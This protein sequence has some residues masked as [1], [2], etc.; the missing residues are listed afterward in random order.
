MLQLN[1]EAFG[2]YCGGCY[3]GIPTWRPNT[4]TRIG[5]I[6]PTK[7]R[8]SSSGLLVA[9]DYRKLPD[10]LHHG[11]TSLQRTAKGYYTRASHTPPNLASQDMRPVLTVLALLTC[12]LYLH[13]NL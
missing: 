12:S 13:V 2:G 7:S 3:P 5:W 6:G 9:Q 11:F 10:G 8:R 4:L 1:C